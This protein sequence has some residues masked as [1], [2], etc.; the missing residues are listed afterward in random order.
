[1]FGALLDERIAGGQVIDPVKVQKPVDLL[2]QDLF[3]L[4][5]LELHLGDSFGQLPSNTISACKLSVPW[6]KLG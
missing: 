3:Q 2:V 6:A 4:L 5:L 1:M